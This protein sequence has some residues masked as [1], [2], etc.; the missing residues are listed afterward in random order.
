VADKDGSSSNANARDAIL[1]TVDG[2]VDPARAAHGDALQADHLARG[3]GVDDAVIQQ[4][5]AERTT[6][7][8]GRRIL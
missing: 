3:I 2:D 7:T 8:A 5:R 1:L 6:G 4:V